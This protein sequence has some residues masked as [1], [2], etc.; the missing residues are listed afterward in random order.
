M[1]H[2]DERHA[3]YMARLVLEAGLEVSPE[4][5]MSILDHLDWVL[6]QNAFL[7]LTSIVEPF[8]AVRLHSVDSLMVL[9]EVLA[10]P[11]G[12]LL[13]L[14]TGA[15]FPGLPLALASNRSA[16]LLDSVAKKCASIAG[17]LAREG[18]EQRIAVE[19]GRAEQLASSRRGDFSV[20]ATRA[21]AG[22]PALLELAAPLLVE[23]GLLVALKGKIGEDEVAAG[24]AAAL[25]V[26]MQRGAV[27]AYLLPDGG[28]SRAA[29]TYRRTSEPRV[30]LPRRVGMAQKKPLG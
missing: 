30:S 9:P 2:L 19:V 8:S 6:E 18:L 25:V 13:D 21:V 29:V 15:G 27:R 23:G 20:V 28:E 1:K 4:A 22:L 10:A 24:D 26:G 7:N 17:F 14:G 11:A 3:G 5:Q 16:V 12:Y